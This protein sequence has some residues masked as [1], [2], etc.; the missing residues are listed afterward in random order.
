MYWEL[1]NYKLG[2]ISIG[3]SWMVLSL[4]AIL[5]TGCG[6]MTGKKASGEQD[7]S[8]FSGILE[9]QIFREDDGC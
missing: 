7:N 9:G 8:V 4:S 3:V 5:H 6:S 1:G 2:M